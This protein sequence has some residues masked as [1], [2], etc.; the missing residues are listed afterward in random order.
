MERMPL[1][2]QE[3]KNPDLILMDILLNGDTDGIETAQ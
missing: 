2:K 3:K 1:K